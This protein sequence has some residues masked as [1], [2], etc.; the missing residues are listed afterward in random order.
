MFPAVPRRR[1]ARPS[2]KSLGFSAVI[3]AVA[4]YLIVY[5]F[6]G[7]SYAPLS[8]ALAMA[9]GVYLYRS[10]GLRRRLPA[11][12]GEGKEETIGAREMTR[13]GL[14]MIVGGVVFV[15]LPLATVFFLPVLFFILYLALPLGLA[16]SEIFQFGWLARL[17]ARIGEEV[18]SITETTEVDGREAVVKTAV[19]IPHDRP[20]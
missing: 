20:D 4:L 12:Y 6:E 8:V 16:L 10:R 11:P 9:V 17:E 2:L 18:Y 15:V 14:L 7:L 19:L 1:R 3:A 13:T 5:L